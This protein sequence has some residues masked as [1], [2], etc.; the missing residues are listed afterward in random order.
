[1]YCTQGALFWLFDQQTHPDSFEYLFQH[2]IIYP[3]DL[4]FLLIPFPLFFIWFYYC[5]EFK[6]NPNAKSFIP[7]Q[8]PV[9]PPSPVS[10]GSFYFQTNVPAISH[11]H[12]PMGVGVSALRQTYMFCSL[13]AFFG[14]I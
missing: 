9:R 10:D 13:L 11:M 7:S 14:N 3:C 6:F 5:Q 8:T 12:M 1:M 4:H 2:R